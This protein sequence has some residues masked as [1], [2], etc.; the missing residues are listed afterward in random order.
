MLVSLLQ[1][2]WKFPWTLS[3]KNFWYSLNVTGY[4]EISMD[5]LGKNIFE[6]VS[7]YITG[8]ME[9]SMD[10]LSKKHF[11]ISLNFRGYT[12]ISIELLGKNI[13]E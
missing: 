5:H 9:I 12:E 6:L 1:D 11:S 2:T 10:P 4:M 3:V 7:M 8:Y 13:F